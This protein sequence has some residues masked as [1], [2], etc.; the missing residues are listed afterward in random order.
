[1]V[2]ST[3]ARGF[4]AAVS[5]FGGTP[6]P[7][8]LNC[9]VWEN[10]A[11]AFARHARTRSSRLYDFQPSNLCCIAFRS[12]FD[13]GLHLIRTTKNPAYFAV[14]RVWK[15]RSIRLLGPAYLLAAQVGNRL[16]DTICPGQ[17]QAGHAIGARPVMAR[18]GDDHGL[19]PI[20]GCHVRAGFH[21]VRAVCSRP[22]FDAQLISFKNANLKFSYSD[23]L[24]ATVR[25]AQRPKHQIQ[26]GLNPERSPAGVPKG[27]GLHCRANNPPVSTPR[28]NR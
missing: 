21:F 12:R 11:G 26:S 19:R 6:P 27:S 28:P 10:P 16:F 25:L 9:K 7:K 4:T 1:M 5:V 14:S 24:S 20:R 18:R 2:Y 22:P 3:P 8:P 17:T 15:T 23:A 13:R